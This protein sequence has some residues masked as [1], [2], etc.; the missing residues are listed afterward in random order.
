MAK[1]DLC[2]VGDG[3]FWSE[4]DNKKVMAY[5]PKLDQNG[6][7]IITPEK[8]VLVES[9]GGIVVGSK[10]VIDGNIIKV[11]RSNVS[12]L[13]HTKGFGASDFVELVPVNLEKYQRVGYFPVEHVRIL[14]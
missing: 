13:A 2:V 4:K 11:S 5:M 8:T 6:E 9:V 10:G 1:H 3:Y 12:S 14:G 7:W